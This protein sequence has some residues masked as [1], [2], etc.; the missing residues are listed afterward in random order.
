ML[1]R[2]I[3]MYQWSYILCACFFLPLVVIFAQTN[4]ELASLRWHQWNE[5]VAATHASGKYMLVDV[6][7]DWC[8]W[9]KKMDREVYGHPQVQQLLAASFELVKLNA[10]SA[11][12][13]TN[14]TN[15]YTDQEWAKMLRVEGYPTIMVYDKRFQLISRFS[16]YR[17]PEKFIRYLKYISGKYY[18]QYT[19]Q[20]YLTKVHDDQ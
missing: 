3:I 17:E 19:F 10:E 2:K 6:Y 14:G 20:E 5:G 15:Q 13:I 1:R 9:C 8:G 7:T 11:N 12:L 18:T 4:E 16:G